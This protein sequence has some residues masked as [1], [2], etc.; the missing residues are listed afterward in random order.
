MSGK[1]KTIK[2]PY[3]MLSITHKFISLMQSSFHKSFMTFLCGKISKIVALL[4]SRL[5]TLHLILIFNCQLLKTYFQ[6]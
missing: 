6:I 1:I 4:F 3:I 5:L 2:K